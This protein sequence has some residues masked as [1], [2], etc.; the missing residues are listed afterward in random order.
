MIGWWWWC[1]S[2]RYESRNDRLSCS[3]LI[4]SSKMRENQSE[5]TSSAQL[6]LHAAAVLSCFAI[7]TFSWKL[8]RRTTINDDMRKEK[9]KKPTCR[10]SRRKA[11]WKEAKTLKRK[12]RT[13]IP[14]YFSWDI[15]CHYG[16]FTYGQKSKQQFTCSQTRIWA[17]KKELKLKSSGS[18][19]WLREILY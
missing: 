5:W 7:C 19:W 6:L 16:Y 17:S 12:K 11:S 9:R 18:C 13:C 14:T 8:R 1:D 15:A 2:I 10:L 4:R 3:L